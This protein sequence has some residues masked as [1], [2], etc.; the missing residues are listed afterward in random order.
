MPK[1]CTN[2]VSSL[3]LHAR[4]KTY[5]QKQ[6]RQQSF[7]QNRA[8]LKVQKCHALNIRITHNTLLQLTQKVY[9]LE[10]TNKIPRQL[11][12]LSQKCFT[13]GF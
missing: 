7:P 5:T 1:C 6:E 4:V 12:H 11:R 13:L 3:I 10:A 2:L 9:L 8:V